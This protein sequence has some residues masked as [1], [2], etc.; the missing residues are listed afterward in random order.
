VDARGWITRRRE[1]VG[2]VAAGGLTYLGLRLA[3]AAEGAVA[4]LV[5]L[6]AVLVVALLTLVIQV[7]SGSDRS[8]AC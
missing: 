8:R 4:V 1:I 6:L 2:A 5:P 3:G 7:V